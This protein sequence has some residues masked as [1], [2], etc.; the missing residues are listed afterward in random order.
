MQTDFDVAVVGYGPSGLVMAAALGKLGHR[1]GV[2]ERWPNLYGLPRLTHI[3]G[4]TARIIQNV[5]DVSTALRNAKPV[6]SYEWA[7]ADG[8]HLITVDWSGESAGYPAHISIYQPEIED[9]LDVSAKSYPNVEVNQGWMLTHISNEQN[10]VVLRVREWSRNRD[11]QWASQ[12]TERTVTARYIVGADGANSS[13]RDALDIE[14]D[15]LQVDDVWLNIDTEQLRE[16]PA[17][18]SQSSQFCDPVRPNMFMPIGEGRQRFE[19]AV[20]PGESH[21]KASTPEYAWRWL[22]ERHQLGPEDVRILRQIVYMF[23]A[24]NAHTWRK[25]RSLLVG[26]AAHTMPPYMGQGACS[27]M[28]DSITLAW[29]LHLVLTGVSP[30]EYLDTYELE[31]RPHAEAIQAMAVQLGRVANTLDKEVAADR[32]RAF[33]FGNVP[34]L[35]PFPTIENGTISS[36][37]VLAGTL[38]PQG[39]ITIGDKTGLADDLLGWGFCIVTN[40]ETGQLLT[41]QQQRFLTALGGKII[42]TL[43]GQPESV[44]DTDRVYETFFAQHL[45]E[46]LIMRPDFHLFGACSAKDLGLLVDEL[47]ES[48]GYLLRDKVASA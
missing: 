15:D 17:R 46:A 44:E 6:D 31:R 39:R 47:Q 2:F 5:A 26:D 33:R 37:A 30:E 34:Q 19:L 40:S 23:S 1:V 29:K 14:R 9:A 21:E 3:D 42:T 48:V 18:F 24:R 11:A 38:A 27:G 13:V 25:G 20:F 41:E 35:P 8:E 43:P 28:R 7:G 10:H 22:N 32:D 16:L 45:V 4:E 36:S 12:A